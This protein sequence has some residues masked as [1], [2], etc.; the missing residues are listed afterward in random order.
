MI[1]WLSQKAF[2]YGDAEHTS[3][4]WETGVGGGVNHQ[5]S[6]RQFLC[7]DGAVLYPDWG[8]GYK[9]LYMC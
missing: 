3:W 9:N 7:G 6:R 8:D 4:L 5:G 2:L 1:P